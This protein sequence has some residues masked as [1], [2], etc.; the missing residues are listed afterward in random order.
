MNL[1]SMARTLVIGGGI[2][3]LALLLVAVIPY[4]R[5]RPQLVATQPAELTFDLP[6]DTTFTVQFDQWLWP[7][8]LDQAVQIDPPLPVRIVWRGAALQIIPLRELTAETTY[9]ITLTAEVRNLLLRSFAQPYTLRF[10]TARFVGLQSA[11]PPPATLDVALNSPISL[12][13]DHD[14]VTTEQIRAAFGDP[15]AQTLLPQP[16]TIRDSAGQVVAGAGRWIAPTTYNFYPTGGLQPAGRYTLAVPQAIDAERR[17][18]LPAP[19]EWTITTRTTSAVRDVRPLNGTA[20]IAL[21]SAVTVYLDP[22]ALAGGALL[23]LQLRESATDRPVQGNLIRRAD[24]IQFTPATPLQAATTYAAA[25][26]LPASGPNAIPTE[27]RW[28]FTTRGLPQVAQAG[29]T[30]AAA[31]VDSLVSVRFDRP[32]VL[33]NG[34]APAPFT[35]QPPI[36]GDGRWIDSFTYVFSPTQNL[37][38][39]QAYRG[40]VDPGLPDAAGLAVR[41]PY[42]WT[43]QIEPLEDDTRSLP[44]LIA[45][46]PLTVT[47]SLPVEP[48]SIAA[49]L[50]RDRTGETTPITL[51]VQ[52]VNVIV[53]P[54]GPLARAESY[55]LSLGANVRSIYGGAPPVT[56]PRWAVDTPPNPAIDETTP[57][58][59]DQNVAPGS[60]AFGGRGIALAFSVPMELNSVLANLTIAPAPAR[61]YTEVRE[62]TIYLDPELLPNTEYLVVVGAGAR[63]VYGVPLGSDYT[64]RF[65]TGAV[66]PAA[67]IVTQLEPDQFDD[68]ESWG[69]LDAAGPAYHLSRLSFEAGRAF[70]TYDANRPVVIALRYVNIPSIEYQLYQVPVAD[71]Q[72]MLSSSAAWQAS[73][74]DPARL[75]DSGTRTL[76]APN[77]RQWLET[78]DL[79]LR[80]PGV[81]QLYVT[82]PGGKADV[83]TLVISRYTLTIKRSADQLFIWAVDLADGRPAAGVPLSLS[84][85][86][87][88]QAIV[89]PLGRTDA[90]GVL[91]VR[92][93]ALNSVPDRDTPL[94]I[95]G[96]LGPDFSFS[97]T[98]WDRDITP[99]DF[100]LTQA[101]VRSGVVGNVYTDK[102]LYNAGQTV[103]IKGMVRIEG[104][105]GYA[106]PEE[107]R[108]VRV[109]VVDPRGTLIASS[110]AELSPVGSFATA[111]AL[112]QM[113]PL[114]GYSLIVELLRLGGTDPAQAPQ[115]GDV[116]AAG[117]IFGSFLVND[118]RRPSFEVRITPE[119]GQALPNEELIFSLQ[120]RL[121]TGEPVEDALVRWRIF[122]MPLPSEPPGADTF[123]FADENGRTV[124]TGQRLI[125]SG[126]TTT[127]RTT[128]GQTRIFFTPGPELEG[129]RLTLVA[130]VTDLAEQL[131]NVGQSVVDVRSGAFQIGIRPER[132]VVLPG[133][134]I[135][136]DLALLDPLGRAVANRPITVSLLRREWLVAQ[137]QGSEG[138]F[139]WTSAASDTPLGVT[140]LSSDAAG[141]TSFTFQPEQGGAYVVQAEALD[142]AGNQIVASRLV[143]SYAPETRWAIDNASRVELVADRAAYAPGD[144]AAVLVQAPY[145]GMTALVTIE[146]GDV[147]E[148]QTLTLSGA[149]GLL[150]IPITDEHTPNIFVGV[151]LIKAGGAD[152]SYPELRVGMIEL[153][154]P[155]VAQRLNIQITPST[156]T[157]APGETVTYTFQVTDQQGA[158][159]QA[160]LSLALIDQR[161][162][163]LARS[164]NRDPTPTFT[165]NLFLTRGIGVETSSGMIQLADRVTV[166]VQP[167][168]KGGGV[169]NLP[170]F[171]PAG[172]DD[173][174]LVRRRFPDT[175]LWEPAL[176]TDE[177]GRAQ[178]TVTLPD[179]LTTWRMVARALT[180]DTRF[181]QATND[182][183]ARR[184][185]FLQPVLPAAFVVGDAGELLVRVQNAGPTALNATVT[186]RNASNDLLQ[187]AGPERQRV[188][189]PPDDAVVLRWPVTARAPGSADLTFGLA[190]ADSVQQIV[191]I[192]P[193][194]VRDIVIDQGV[195]APGESRTIRVP[196]AALAD[197]ASTLLFD[198]QADA[199]AIIGADLAQLARPHYQNSEAL[200]SSFLPALLAAREG[201]APTAP[202]PMALAAPL[203]QLY[204]MQ[205]IDGG[206]GWWAGD[207]L[208]TPYPSAY[209]TH[210]LVVARREGYAVDPA[211]LERALRYL[212]RSLLSSALDPEAPEAWRA[213]V[214]SYTLFVLA[215]A[216]RSDAGQTLALYERRDRLGQ[217][218]KAYLLRALLAL[219]DQR[220][221]VNVL[222]DEVRRAALPNAAGVFWS[223]REHAP[224]TMSSDVRSSAVVLGALQQHDPHDPLLP[225]AARALLALRTAEGWA[226]SHDTA[227]ALIALSA[228][229]YTL[230]EAQPISYSI[231]VDGRILERNGAPGR[232]V[233]P[234]GREMIVEVPGTAPAVL[235]TLRRQVTADPTTLPGIAQGMSL[236]RTYWPVDRDTLV[237]GALP[238]AQATPGE[239]VLVQFTL[240]LPRPARY[241]VIEDRL[242]AGLEPVELLA[243]EANRLLAP[244]PAEP[245]DAARELDYFSQVAFARSGA[246]IFATNI[247]AGVYRYSYLARAVTRG[248]Y[249]APPARAFQSYAPA[250]LATSA[251]RR[252]QVVDP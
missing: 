58:D 186:L 185:I 10:S 115:D 134:A 109:S 30:D 182:L 73:Q 168:S 101:A 35:L 205:T 93:A 111:F 146:R 165:D 154:V 122:A 19:L 113:A 32:M 239:L 92:F 39:G 147:L 150:E 141:R 80:E 250:T 5:S 84:F 87:G 112:D 223:E 90:D 106:L 26:T 118:Y 225:G 125:A 91:D 137:Q 251:S 22:Q 155:A 161:V 69:G 96:P 97:S 37:P 65:R 8:G 246:A 204:R 108:R 144:T 242:P 33:Q 17:I 177:Q 148:Y 105:R 167:G 89:R 233:L 126:E 193:V 229:S 220:E 194:P 243:Q 234:E 95:S 16:L 149:A 173:E 50:I 117:D 174:V 145:P 196:E 153:Q 72:R 76:S 68:D 79:G 25:L 94:L 187:L 169:P 140:Q 191:T 45:G 133:A 151:T 103:N 152:L 207:R 28:T 249:L 13:F 228:V 188:S 252:F 61:L 24:S 235:Y 200:V 212:E 34:P 201:W 47:F 142:D 231:A 27:Y 40:I 120:A 166:Q 206:W 116:L 170:R 128:P 123:S 217:Y 199:P 53:T 138:R 18:R 31:P 23:D 38:P 179:N 75:V 210:G 156:E 189:V 71:A 63:D 221:R 163:E 85:F 244:P 83:Q 62:A 119:Q 36:L 226:H 230:V 136:V 64:F 172:I 195:V 107:G 110:L 222:A 44:Q 158:G 21:D 159:R 203:Q 2:A 247:P 55:T 197:G 184:D 219:G 192:D 11:T 70:V 41:E 160:E 135:T 129:Q 132:L 78:L 43:F 88:E 213:D 238:I 227:Q 178:V 66:R 209:V 124:T 9:Q 181:G 3:L 54:G 130:E 57:A 211:I 216:G 77:D 208:G 214:R 42:N 100:G 60:V 171:A 224:D 198:V 52:G 59:G 1:R 6:A 175:A 86:D 20:E 7:I 232:S 114:G 241:L 237:P 102:P 164:L 218:G 162:L 98:L 29:P 4:L 74:P 121:F 15:A 104:D 183:I 127:G 14:L 48:T 180:A 176:L 82:E 157:A 67:Q 139:Y 51:A 236:E 240:T 245:G 81:Y 12:R 46:N 131:V 56:P 99:S 190:G 49:Q 202:D 248:D 143:Y 215:E